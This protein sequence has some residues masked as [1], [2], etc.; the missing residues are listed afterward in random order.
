M[1]V[2]WKKVGMPR[3][4]DP[5]LGKM[6]DTDLAKL[7]GS[8]VSK[9]RYRRVLLGIE[10]YANF[11]MLKPFI[12]LLGKNSDRA[13]SVQAGVSHSAVKRFREALGIGAFISRS[14]QIKIS[15]HHPLYAYRPLVGLIDDSTLAQ[16]ANTSIDA[17]AAQRESM[18]LK[19]VPPY[20]H[21]SHRHVLDFVGPLLGYESLFGRMSD[22]KIS[23]AT[24]VSVR[25]IEQR[26]EF[27]GLPRFRQ[28]S[29][30]EPYAHLLEVVPAA[31]LSQ[32]TGLSLSRITRLRKDR[33]G[34]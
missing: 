32:L 23:R 17:V 21:P 30:I 1:S 16:L 34:S 25:I 8:T 26:R 9:V 4:Y 20:V 11:A 14:E 33:S 13:I 6:R 18:G 27:L 12:P 2:D 29:R 19:S 15:K 3:W 31:L 28:A 22:P 5:K 10:A 7:I 24:G